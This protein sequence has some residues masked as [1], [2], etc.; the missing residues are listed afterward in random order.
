MYSVLKNS[1]FKSAALNIIAAQVLFLVIVLLFTWIGIYNIQ[2]KV[3]SNNEAL[4]GKVLYTHPGYENEITGI[5]TKSAT[6]NEINTGRNILK[7]TDTVKKAL[8]TFQNLL[9]QVYLNT[10][11]NMK[12][13]LQYCIR[14]FS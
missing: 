1:E 13:S 2:K 10:M 9:S 8:E 4:L 5:I 6:R 11:E 14:L 7:S 12:C 3:I